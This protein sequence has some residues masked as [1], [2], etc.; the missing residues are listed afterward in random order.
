MKV[1][2]GIRVPTDSQLLGRCLAALPEALGRHSADTVVVDNA[3]GDTSA[4][5]ARAMGATVVVNARNRGYARAMNQALHGAGGEFVVALNPDTLPR[6]RSLELLVDHLA[7][8]DDAGLVTP[9]LV[10]TPMARSS[11]ASTASRRPRSGW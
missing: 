5:I 7:A 6:P 11:R 4:D 2:V 9:R 3:S 8:N 10:N 1:R